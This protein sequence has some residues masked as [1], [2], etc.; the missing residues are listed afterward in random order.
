MR[1]ALRTLQQQLCFHCRHRSK[2]QLYCTTSF[3][4]LC[5]DQCSSTGKLLHVMYQRH[6]GLLEAGR[7]RGAMAAWLTSIVSAACASLQSHELELGCAEGSRTS[8]CPRPF[9]GQKHPPT[10]AS[11]SSSHEPGVPKRGVPQRTLQKPH[12]TT[13]ASCS[14]HGHPLVR[15]LSRT[16]AHHAEPPQPDLRQSAQSGGLAHSGG[17]LRREDSTL[18]SAAPGKGAEE[19]ARG[20]LPF[21]SAEL[22]QP[23]DEPFRHVTK[24]LRQQPDAPHQV[25]SY[26]AVLQT[27]GRDSGLATAQAILAF[28]AQRSPR[29]GFFGTRRSPDSLAQRH[30][31]ASSHD[32]Q[33]RMLRSPSSQNAKPA[34]KSAGD[35]LFIPSTP[36]QERILSS[37]SCPYANST[38]ISEGEGR[39][40]TSTPTDSIPQHPSMALATHAAAGRAKCRTMPKVLHTRQI[41]YDV[42][43]QTARRLGWVLT[44]IATR[45]GENKG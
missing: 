32:L 25:P 35:G 33:E 23:R 39:F 10:R 6:R 28:T 42:G 34:S 1:C 40:E 45:N 41:V 11:S 9:C 24:S 38:P 18:V 37:P 14:A 36:I 21:A 29:H 8:D 30:Q 20:W 44:E 13:P 22:G 12:G 27:H 31:G 2:V 15:A 26:E 16:P 3:T 19:Y 4:Q 7:G 43:S 5:T 17:E